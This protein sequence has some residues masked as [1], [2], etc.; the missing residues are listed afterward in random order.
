MTEE[1]D[2]IMEKYLSDMPQ[3]VGLNLPKLKKSKDAPSPK[4]KLPKL[5]KVTNNESVSV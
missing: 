3:Q 1:L 5:K 4:I 2:S